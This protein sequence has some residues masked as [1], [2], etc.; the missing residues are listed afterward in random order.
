M[1]QGRSRLGASS[2]RRILPILFLVTPADH[3]MILNN[4]LYAVFVSI[5]SI[6]LFSHGD[7]CSREMHSKKGSVD[8]GTSAVV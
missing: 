6:V 8:I 3:S 1:H 4:L 2:Q 7:I 5:L